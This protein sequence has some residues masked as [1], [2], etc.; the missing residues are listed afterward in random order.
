M[1]ALIVEDDFTSRTVL[2]RFLAEDFET[3]IAID[4]EQ[5]CQAFKQAFTN[6]EKYDVVFL[7]IMMPKK[8]GLQVLKEIR[9]YEEDNG[10]VDHSGVKIIMTTALDDSKNVLTAF[11]N[12]CEGYI[13]KPFNRQKIYSK[14]E[15]LGLLNQNK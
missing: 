5:A 13:V 7:D 12:G 2:Q 3:N 8:D 14:I 15:E 10:L 1:K 11:K 9:K 6:N 4:G